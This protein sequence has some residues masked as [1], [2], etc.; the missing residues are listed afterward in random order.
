MDFGPNSRVSAVIFSLYTDG[1]L[2]IGTDVVRLFVVGT[3]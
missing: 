1:L 3:F 2:E